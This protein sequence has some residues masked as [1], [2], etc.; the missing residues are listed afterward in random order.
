MGR[1]KEDGVMMMMAH[2]FERVPGNTL[3]ALYIFFISSWGWWEVGAAIIWEEIRLR[4]V[5]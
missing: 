5:K 2:G 4:E 1:M 3:S